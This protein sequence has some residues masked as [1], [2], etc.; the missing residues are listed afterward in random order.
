VNAFVG[1]CRGE[2]A[3]V[4]IIRGDGAG[5]RDGISSETKALISIE[6]TTSSPGATMTF[7]HANATAESGVFRT[8][9]L[10]CV[11]RLVWRSAAGSIAV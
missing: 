4:R 8:S 3:L 6:R 1:D 7:D 5:D 11:H 10:P 2:A 9:S